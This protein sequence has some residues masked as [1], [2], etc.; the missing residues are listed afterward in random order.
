MHEIIINR[1]FNAILRGLIQLIETTNQAGPPINN[2]V[3]APK[4]NTKYYFTT[5]VMKSNANSLD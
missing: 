4:A 1:H 3:T 5:F 2:A